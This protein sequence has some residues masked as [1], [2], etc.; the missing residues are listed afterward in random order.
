[1]GERISAVVVGGGAV[2]TRKAVALH[3]SGA[4]VRVIAPELSSILLEIAERSERFSVV[5]REYADVD[6][7]READIVIAATDV[8]SVNSRIAADAQ[9]IHR[10]VSVVTAGDA[11]SFSSM[12]V[13]RAGQ[14][15]IGVGAGHVPGAAARIRDVIAERFDDRYASALARCADIRADA[16]AKGRDEW[17]RVSNTLLGPEFCQRVEDGMLEEAAP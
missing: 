5:R 12:A 15:T 6:D 7:I 1:M 14:L 9:S 4:R 8:A 16:L 17:A 10:L 3:E 2:A 11:G 13:H